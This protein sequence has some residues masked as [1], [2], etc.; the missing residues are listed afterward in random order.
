MPKSTSRKAAVALALLLLCAIAAFGGGFDRELRYLPGHTSSPSAQTITM[1]WSAE[2]VEAK[3]AGKVRF[4]GADLA[5]YLQAGD[6][7]ISERRFDYW[8][9]K[10]W[11]PGMAVLAS[12]SLW[13]G[14]DHYVRNLVC[15]AVVLWAGAFMVLFLTLDVSRTRATVVAVAYLAALLL[16]PTLRHF[17]FGF[18]AVMSEA[19]S[20]AFFIASMSVLF[21]AIARRSLLLFTAAGVLLGIATLIRA[22]FEYI[23]HG[24]LLV[25][26]LLLGAAWLV[27]RVRNARWAN[28]QPWLRCLAGLALAFIAFQTTLVP[29]RMYSRSTY[30]HTSL[31]HLSSDYVYGRTWAPDSELR[32]YLRASNTP[33]VIEPELCAALQPIRPKLSGEAQRNLTAMTL[34]TR[35]FAFTRHKLEN[36]NWLWIGRD[37]RTAF[38]EQPL[39][40]LEAVLLLLV[41]LLTTLLVTVRAYTTRDPN[42][43]LLL[44]VTGAFVA[45]NAAMFVILPFEWRYSLPLRLFAYLLP[46]WWWVVDR[47]LRTRF[48]GLSRPSVSTTVAM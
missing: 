20:C 25:M 19:A 5:S 41:G 14:R 27:A 29:W 39:L 30:G 46:A 28:Q 1:S 31:L 36:F 18:G 26:P 42:L 17:L 43:L 12:A 37:W 24:L 32:D 45:T 33:C 40:G 13:M 35:P 23:G 47:R 8:Y 15:M 11:P 44:L 10:I 21:L 6:L 48:D 3:Y 22:Y 9:S 7:L 4:R 16:M 34:L 2:Q 38:V